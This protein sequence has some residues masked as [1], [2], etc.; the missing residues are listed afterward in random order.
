MLPAVVFIL[1]FIKLGS[2]FYS[3]GICCGVCLRIQKR[4]IITGFC[5]IAL[6]INARAG[7]FKPAKYAGDFFETGIGAR[8]LAMGGAFSAAADDATAIF[9]NPAGLVQISGLEIHGM[10]SERFAGA[11]NRDFLGAAKKIGETRAFGIGFFRLGVD[12]I[13]FTRLQNP[14][15]GLGTVYIDEQ[16]R[17]VIN[18]PEIYKTLNHADMSLVLTYSQRSNEKLSFGMNIKIHQ[19]TNEDFKAWGLGF[20]AG[21]LW[22]PADNL[23]ASAVLSDAT[24]TLLAWQHGTKERI[25]PHLRIGAAYSADWKSFTILPVIDFSFGFEGRGSAAQLSFGNMDMDIRSGVEFSYLSRA[26]FRIGLDRTF[27]TAGFGLSFSS[28]QIDY[29]FSQHADLGDTHRISLA[30][31]RPEREIQKGRNL[32]KNM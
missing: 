30:F 23:R 4:L 2:I 10:H 32:P 22:H 12:N 8:A 20:D 13:P 3:A 27:L 29:G 17:R 11:V 16:G 19:K 1:L 6:S 24:T 18:E 26:A 21:V 14:D 7:D 9:W 31:I 28:F 25:F 15:M 5:C